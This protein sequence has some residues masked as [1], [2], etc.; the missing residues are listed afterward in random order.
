MIHNRHITKD[1]DQGFVLPYTGR[2]MALCGKRVAFKYVGIPSVTS[3]PMLL[4]TSLGIRPGWCLTCARE[5][6]LYVDAYVANSEFAGGSEALREY[7]LNCKH[8]GLSCMVKYFA[9][10]PAEKTV[11]HSEVMAPK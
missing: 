8:V 10:V 7:Q 1:Y 11:E 9:E 2:R 6:S 3:Q 5:L 4:N